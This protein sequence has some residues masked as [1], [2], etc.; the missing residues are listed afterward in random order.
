[1]RNK[2]ELKVLTDLI[3]IMLDFLKDLEYWSAV[4]DD[5]HNEEIQKIKE[6]LLGM[7]N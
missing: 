6:L 1:M 2:K 5:Q 4:N 3:M 7:L